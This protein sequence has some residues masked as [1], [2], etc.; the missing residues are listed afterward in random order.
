[1]AGAT[2]YLLNKIAVFL[3]VPLGLFH[4]SILLTSS[5]VVCDLRCSIGGVTAAQAMRRDAQASQMNFYRLEKV[6]IQ[7]KAM[8]ISFDTIQHA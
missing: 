1:M 7:I 6:T 5:V 4:L 2:V 3:L 8:D